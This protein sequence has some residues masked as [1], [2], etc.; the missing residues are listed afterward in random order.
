MKR[1]WISLVLVLVLVGVFVI[2]EDADYLSYGME[3][4]PDGKYEITRD[5][6]KGWNLLPCFLPSLANIKEDISKEDIRA[7]W[8]YVP[9]INEYIQI[10]PENQIDDS[11]GVDLGVQIDENQLLSSSCWYYMEKSGDI[12]Y[13]TPESY[14]INRELSQGWNFIV[15]T[16]DM[17][18]KKIKDLGDCKIVDKIAIWENGLQKWEL[19]N[20]DRSIS[21]GF[22]WEDLP[23]LAEPWDAGNG[24]LW[25]TPSACTLNLFSSQSGEMPPTI[26]SFNQG[27]SSKKVGCLEAV[28]TIWIGEEEYTFAN[29]ST[30][31]IS[32]Q[33]IRGAG[34]FELVGIQVI[35]AVEGNAYTEILRDNL[36]GVNEM[37]VSVLANVQRDYGSA[38]K[39]EIAPIIKE[40]A[41]EKNC[42]I[43]SSVDL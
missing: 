24:V 4:L 2:A 13:T 17:M 1:L 35:V 42:D 15:L 3:E 6:S 7:G 18:N 36:P 16:P 43:S 38:R 21:I 9:I 37:Q 23:V 31:E 34:D 32:L 12:V 41:V 20:P 22:D 33:I 29:S 40:G 25:Y 14:P 5:V 8:M 26:P 19:N 11:I 10:H 39:V 27:T 28:S 30:D